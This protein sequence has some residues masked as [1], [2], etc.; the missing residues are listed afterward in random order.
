MKAEA[1]SLADELSAQLLANARADLA[2]YEHDGDDQGAAEQRLVIRGLEAEAAGF[3]MSVV[4]ISE[5]SRGRPTVSGDLNALHPEWRRQVVGRLALQRSRT[6]RRHIPR[7]RQACVG[8]NRRPAPRR[9]TCSTRGSPGG[10]D[11]SDPGGDPEGEPHPVV[12]LRR[13]TRLQSEAFT[14]LGVIS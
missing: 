13:S 2:A 4:C 6:M 11:D 9:S 10:G 7:A 3:K 5:D 12:L 1:A 14:R 8:G